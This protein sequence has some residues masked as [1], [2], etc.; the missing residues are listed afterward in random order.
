MFSITLAAL[1]LGWGMLG[2]AVGGGLLGFSTV[3]LVPL[4][5][6]WTWLVPGWGV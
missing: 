2:D 1:G 6:G 5:S 3:G 4:L